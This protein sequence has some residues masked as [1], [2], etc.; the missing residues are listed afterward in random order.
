MIN[1]TK[2]HH[3]SECAKLIVKKKTNGDENMPEALEKLN[4]KMTRRSEQNQENLANRA[5]HSDDE[6]D[7]I[8]HDSIGKQKSSR[9][10]NIQSGTLQKERDDCMSDLN[11]TSSESNNTRN[12]VQFDK[13]K[14]SRLIEKQHHYI[15]D[16]VVQ[17]NKKS[18]S[19]DKKADTM[20]THINNVNSR[21]DFMDNRLN[22]IEQK[23]AR[24]MRLIENS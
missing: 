2:K 21:L 18:S 10:H 22:S 12:L 9:C 14:I 23:L 11:F 19:L 8:S 20:T 3:A 13:E 24:L 4:T 1:H 5:I 6:I 17:L 15:E 7:S 16:S